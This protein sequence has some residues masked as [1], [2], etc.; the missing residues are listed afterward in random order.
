MISAVR[1][2]VSAGLAVLLLSAGCANQSPRVDPRAVGFVE[3][4]RYTR[5]REHLRPHARDLRSPDVILDNQR[6]AV[7]ALHDGATHDAEAALTRAYPFM[8]TG[9]VNPE[10]RI[11]AAK[12]RYEG[13]LVWRGEPFEQAM[14]WY[15]QALHRMQQRDWENARAAARN[16]TFRLVD[17][18][19]VRDIDEAMR[20]AESPEWLNEHA[21][22]VESDLVLGWILEALAERHIPRPARAAELFDHARDLRPDL[23]PLLDRLE[24]DDWNTLL[25]VETGRGP[26]KVPVGEYGQSFI[27][28]PEPTGSASGAEHPVRLGGL[29]P[30]VA[31]S[32]PP[33]TGVVDTWALARHPRWWSLAS[34]R[35]L[36]AVVGEVTSAVGLGAV[37]VGSSLSDD[38]TGLVVA[39]AGLATYGIGQAI[40][41]GS[42]AD[43]RHLDVLPRRVHLLPLRLPPG[44]RHAITLEH[45]GITVTRHDLVAGTST[46][47]ATY[48]I[49]VHEDAD[50]AP[51]L[52][53]AIAH[54]NDHVGPIPGTLPYILGGTCVATPSPRTLAAYQVGG[55]LLDFTVEDLADLYRA[56]GIAIGR[57]AADGRGARLHVLEGGQMLYVPRPGSAGYE[58]L[59]YVPK[60]PYRPRSDRV[61]ELAARLASDSAL[62]R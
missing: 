13:L 15:Y 36:K 21:E 46:D 8:V 11:R 31:A 59:T 4:G 19:G 20:R 45:D 34:L 49:R 57:P 41:S 6:L 53:A 1:R 23:V 48:A 47:P 24:H 18:A 16:M 61:R 62:R 33:G 10:D 39:L 54:P 12:F 27:F 30:E 3:E 29:P 7:A 37:V 40:A 28:R 58:W 51:G 25:V 56:E 5:A 2:L 9:Q 22:F 35:E 44:R 55:H 32:L 42:A 17:I 14:A 26:E 43:L 60:P 38:E 52:A 50:P